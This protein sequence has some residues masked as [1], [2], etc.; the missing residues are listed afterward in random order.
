[1]V[2]TATYYDDKT[3][4]DGTNGS[5]PDVLVRRVMNDGYDREEAIRIVSS[6]RINGGRDDEG[7]LVGSAIVLGGGASFSGDQSWNGFDFNPA[8]VPGVLPDPMAHNAEGR[9]AIGLN[10]DGEVGPD[11]WEHPHT[12]ETGIDN[13]MWRVLGCWDV[14]YVNKPVNPYNEGI[15]WDSAVDA[16]PAW[17][18]SIAGE[19]LDSDGYVTV[20]FNRA[21]NIPLR[22]AYGSIMSGASFGVDSNPR[23]HSEFKGR[24]ENI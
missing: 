9:Y 21:I 12:G 7:N 8:N 23:S 10:L 11:S 15:A 18:I 24:I 3:C 14:Y 20:T 6:L 4:P 1:M 17:L 5:R 19:D 16:M 2:H 13:Q 22:D